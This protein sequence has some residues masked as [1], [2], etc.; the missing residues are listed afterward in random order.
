M[1]CT[2]CGYVGEPKD[3]STT[4]RSKDGSR[5]ACKKCR[6]EAA[7]RGREKARGKAEAL[8]YFDL[9]PTLIG[10][11]SKARIGV[12]IMN[13]FVDRESRRKKGFYNINIGN[14]GLTAIL[15]ELKEPYEYCP[16][17]AINQF[18]YVLVSLTS[19]MDVENL[20]YN[21]EL[22]APL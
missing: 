11:R 22:Y 21:M 20:I 19:V 14:A 1:T 16:P 3:F 9:L 18:E 4:N 2:E 13:N 12:L 8:P 6:R 15:N 17:A 10:V 7:I 5:A